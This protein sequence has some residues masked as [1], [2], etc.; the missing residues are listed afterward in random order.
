MESDRAAG[1]TTIRHGV[2]RKITREASTQ[3]LALLGL[4]GSRTS[5]QHRPLWV[6]AASST[7]NHVAWAG[8]TKIRAG[9]PARETPPWT[10]VDPSS[11]ARHAILPV[12]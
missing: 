12:G 2:G 1:D 8:P 4:H 9:V 11:S 3:P 7:S 10:P 5:T 6:R